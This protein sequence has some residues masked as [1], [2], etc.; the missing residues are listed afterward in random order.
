MATRC[1]SYV[2][3]RMLRATRLDG[4]GNPVYGD[5]SVVTSKGFVSVA[6]TANID[7]GAEVNVPNAAGERC[8]YEPAVPTF[9][10]YTVEITFCDVDPDLYAMLTGQR[11]LTNAFGDVVGFTMDSAVSA[12]DSAFA[13]EVW[14]GSPGVACAPGS[15]GSYGYVLLPYVQGGVVGDFTIENAEVT[16]TISNATTKDGNAWGTGPYE[17]VL[18][19]TS[20]PSALPEPILATD[21]LILL[22]TGVAPPDA[23][24]GARPLLDPA[25]AVLTSVT[26]TP[27]LLS[28]SFAPVPV[29]TDPWWIDFGDNEWDYEPTGG[30]IVHVYAAAG[31]YTYT[32]Y[33]GTSSYSSTV[34]VA[35]A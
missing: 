11:V 5:A 28:V 22:L 15:T 21:H 26:A 12:A 33:R 16:F 13:L 18:D 9:L 6:Y 25:D 34:T 10:S 31:T 29:G 35:A 14:A 4:C 27:T 24:C 20:A 32:A 7:D 8:I 3:G 1:A 19:I 17:V 23:E 2:R 30:N